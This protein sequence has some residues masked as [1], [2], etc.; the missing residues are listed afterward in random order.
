[1][2][3]RLEND[4]GLT[5]QHAA[6]E[7]P[8]SAT[9]RTDCNLPRQSGN[10]RVNTDVVTRSIDQFRSGSNTAETILTPEA[11]RTRGIK[12]L[13]TLQTRDDPRL[14][15]QPLYL[16]GVAIGD[17]PR[18]VVYQATMGNT[19][20]AW[21]ADSGETLWQTQLGTPIN[22]SRDTDAWGINPKWGIVSTPFIDRAA[23]VLYAC[24]WISLDD[25]GNWRTG[26]HFLV[27]LS[28]VT[29]QQ[30]QPPLSLDGATY[31]PGHGL[32][33]QRFHS[34]EHRQRAALAMVDGAVI[35]C[36]GTIADVPRTARGWVIAVDTAGWSVAATWCSTSCGCGGSIWMSGAGPA[37][38]SDGAIWLVTGHGSY[39]GVADFGES[40]VRLRYAR[41]TADT[42]ASLTVSGW[43]TPWTDDSR[44]GGTSDGDGAW[45]L[46]QLPTPANFQLVPHLARMG[47][48][49]MDMGAAWGTQD[50]GAGGIVLIE[51]LGI[52]LVSGMDGILYTIDIADPGETRPADLVEANTAA[53]Y[54]KLAAAPILYTY[55]EAWMDPATPDP[56]ALNRLPMNRTHDLHGTPVSWHSVAHGQM[57]FC[58]GGNG[59]L[60]AWSVNSNKSSLYLGCSAAMASAEAPVPPGGMP[61]W[62]IVLSAN[63]G[64]QGVVWAMIPYGDSNT[65]LTRGRLIAYD[66]AQLGRYANGSGELVPLWDSQDWSWDFLHPKFNRPVAVDGRILVPTYDGRVLVLGLA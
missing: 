40:V 23:G 19:V 12:I 59:N 13:H 8:P 66:A 39:D 56:A 30:I 25:T 34:A 48:E 52:G 29:G 20:Y 45:V 11:V 5:L 61:G 27:A 33:V 57:H 37:V 7:K 46:D 3:A 35:I 42:R 9:V 58:G 60:R 44:A 55:Y 54:A 65:H 50:L 6:T 47:V 38:Q 31:A 16:S 15:A 49:A 17:R 10:D 43:W 1:M 51:H 32:A 41:A 62:S 14:E 4:A 63:G 26:R 36:F 53:N 21:D 28:I 2:H 64:D 24:A 18:D 22:G